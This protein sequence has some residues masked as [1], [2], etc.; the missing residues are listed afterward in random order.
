MKKIILAWAVLLISGLTGAFANKSE[1]VNQ[2][3]LASFKHDFSTAKDV[4]WQEQKD[5]IK[6][7]FSLNEQVMYAFYNRQGDL[8]GVMRHVISSQLPLNLLMDLKKTYLTGYWISDVIEMSV[9]GQTKYYVSLENGDQTLILKAE[10]D[11]EWRTHKTFRKNI[12]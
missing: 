9:D 11:G 4:K 2:Q 3:A 7:T 1:D 5:Y 10:G 6:A 12:A 8:L